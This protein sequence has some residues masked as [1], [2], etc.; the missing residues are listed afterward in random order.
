MSNSVL[1]RIHKVRVNL[2][3]TCNITQSYVEKDDLW[4]GILA[5]AEFVIFSTTNRIKG[6]SLGKLIF[7]RDMIIAIKH[8]VDW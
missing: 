5:A 7:G 3:R 6:Y 4:L 1:E 2:V 8:T